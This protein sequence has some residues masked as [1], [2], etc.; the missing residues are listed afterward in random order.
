MSKK[1]LM[2]ME[3]DLDFELGTELTE[4]EEANISGGGNSS[5]SGSH[6]Y[7]A[8]CVPGSWCY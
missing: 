1:D 3:L 8:C 7:S 4:N 2:E 6:T 5:D